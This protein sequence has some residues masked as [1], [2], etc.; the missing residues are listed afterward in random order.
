VHDSPADWLARF[1]AATDPEDQEAYWIQFIE[2]LREGPIE[3]K[4]AAA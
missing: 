4:D 1:Q 2:S 3:H